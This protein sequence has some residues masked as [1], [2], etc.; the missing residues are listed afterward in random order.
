MHRETLDIAAEAAAGE[1]QTQKKE[2]V[3]LEDFDIIRIIGK[4]GQGQVAQVHLA[5]LLPRCSVSI[6]RSGTI[7]VAKCML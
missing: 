3:C 1:A 4:G 6:H 2:S 5:Y 7:R